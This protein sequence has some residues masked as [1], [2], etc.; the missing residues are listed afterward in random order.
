MSNLENDTL[1]KRAGHAARN[2][3]VLAALASVVALIVIVLALSIKDAQKP[4]A[5]M[6]F[7]IVLIAS[8][9]W[10]LAVAA[11]RGNPVAPGIVIVLMIAQFVL[12]LA[13]SSVIAALNKTSFQFNPGGFIVPVLV[14]LALSSSRNVLLELR[15]R[16]LWEQA[17]PSAKPSANLCLVGGIILG[18]GF[19]CLNAGMVYVGSRVSQEQ[20][21]EH[22]QA[23]AFVQLVKQD[24]TKFMDSM[25]K[26]SARHGDAE[27]NEA[28][29]N[30]ATLEQNFTALQKN[31]STSHG[32]LPQ[33][34]DT[35]GN[36]VRQWKNGLTLL[37]EPHPDNDRALQMLKLGDK[38][39]ADAGKEFDRRY[40]SPRTP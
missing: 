17:F 6:A 31:T 34:L 35:Y 26:L 13:V 7:S 2:L 25:Q 33:I 40:A 23:E 15:K 3:F 21:S 28:M 10:I 29:A 8:A 14:I 11:R 22:Q 5:P 36:A 19:L 9:Y 20:Q 37:K 32:P 18:L 12:G 38:F 1:L 16:G 30:L 4:M 27:L 24:E 39:R